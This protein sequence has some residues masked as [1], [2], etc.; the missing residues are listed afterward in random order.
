MAAARC[1]SVNFIAANDNVKLYGS[2][3]QKQAA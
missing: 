2:F 1:T 3:F